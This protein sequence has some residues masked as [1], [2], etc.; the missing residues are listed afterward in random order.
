MSRATV[1]DKRESDECTIIQ[2]GARQR[3]AVIRTEVPPAPRRTPS[4]SELQAALLAARRGQFA[5]T[6]ASDPVISGLAAPAAVRPPAVHRGSPIHPPIDEERST[7]AARGVWLLGVHGGSGARCLSAVLPG[8]RR[9]TGPEAVVD[10]ADAVVLVCRGSY[11]GLTAAQDCARGYR[12]GNGLPRA[13]VLGVVV[14]ADA[15]GRVPVPLRRLERR[16]SGA[17]PV[18]GHVPWVTQWRLGPPAPGSPRPRWVDTI[19]AAIGAASPV[20]R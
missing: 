3:P 13:A 15:P 5:A 9:A 7:P 16:L 10:A 8:A 1:D 4:V 17:L 18:L 19:V 11:R 12:D 14:S 6:A 2:Y 20:V